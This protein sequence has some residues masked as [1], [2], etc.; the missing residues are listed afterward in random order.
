MLQRALRPHIRRDALRTRSQPSLTAPLAPPWLCPLHARWSTRIASVPSSV[1]QCPRQVAPSR[2]DT[3]SVATITQAE[4]ALHDSHAFEGLSRAFTSRTQS[5]HPELAQLPAWDS[6]RLLLID[7][8]PSLTTKPVTPTKVGVGGDPTELHQ[9]L[10]ACLR[11]GRM[12]R[13]SAILQRLS[14]TYDPSAPELADAH[15]LYL[16]T[17]FEV[18]E[19]NPSPNAMTEIEAWYETNMVAKGI[20]PTPQTLVTLLRASMNFPEP[21]NREGIMRR[22]LDM[23]REC[24][25]AF[26]EDVNASPDFTDE[27]WD[28]LIKLQSDQ[29]DVPPAPEAVQKMHISTPEGMALAIQHGFVPDP[30]LA[31]KPVD[32]KGL[33]L[34]SLKQALNLFEGKDTIPYPHEMEGSKE[35]K[36]RAY[37]YMRQIRLEQDALRAATERWQA[38]DEKLQEMG[39]HGVLQS[40]PL[41]A[42]LWR[43]YSALLPK[44]EE[45]L[46]R[47]REVLSNPNASNMRDERHIYGPHLEDM[48]LKDLAATTLVR[49]LS[50]VASG[51]S[52]ALKL[53]SITVTIGCDIA[54]LYHVNAKERYNSMV[55][56]LRT[57]TRRELLGNLSKEP[58]ATTVESPAPAAYISDDYQGKEIPDVVR[59]K[60]GA[61]LL[62]LAMQ[63]SFITLTRLDPKTGEEL[64]S[65]QP[66]FRQNSTYTLGKRITYIV[67]HDEIV[68]KLQTDRVDHIHTVRLPMLAEPKP[69]TA[70]HE[71]GYYTLREAAVRA[72]GLD[73]AQNAYITSA[74]ENG[75]ME[76]VLAGLDALGRVPWKINK[77]VFRVMVES[78]N[79]GLDIAGLVPDEP[80]LRKPEVP[81]EPS[82][83]RQR[84]EYMRQ[85]KDYENTKQG[86]HSEKCFQNFQLEVARSYLNE[87]K[88][89]Y[90][91]SVDFRGRA[92]PI[93]PLL[94]HIG[95][96]MSRGLLLFA[97]GKE[98]GES[99]LQWLKIHMANLYG[100]DKASLKDREIFTDNNLDNILDSANNPVD[101]KRWWSQA[102]DPWQCL[103][104]CVEIRNALQ[105]PDPTRYVSH[106]PVHQD[107]TC[108]G[109]QHYAALGGDRAGASQVNLE[110][111]DKPQ[112]IY[113]GV[114]EIVKE[115]VAKDAEKD[116]PF[117][118]FVEGKITRSVVK[119]TVMTNV[120]GVTF[121]GAQAQV[122][123]SLKDMF[124]NFTPQGGIGDLSGP[125]YYIAKKIFLALGRIFN[126][127]QEIQTWLGECGDRITSSLS[128][129]QVQKIK[130]RF[131]GRHEMSYDPK[132]SKTRKISNRTLK[133]MDQEMEAFKSTI[134]W[135]TPLKMPVVQPYRKSD[136]VRSIKTSVSAISIRAPGRVAVVSKRKQLQAFPPNFIHSLDATHMTLSAL[137]CAE[138]GIDFAAVHDSFWTHA[139]D[140]PNLNVILRNAFVRMHSE[141]IVGRL[142]AEFKAR[143]AGSMYLATVKPQS[144]VAM[145]IRTWR[146]EHR[147]RRGFQAHRE[148]PAEELALEAQRQ[149]L[150]RSEDPELRKKGEE[151]TTPTSI[152]LRYA[153]PTSLAS[154]RLA[155]LGQT[156]GKQAKKVQEKIHKS[157]TEVIKEV[158]QEKGVTDE[159]VVQEGVAQEVAEKEVAE[160]EDEL[161][162]EEGEAEAE[163]EAIEEEEGESPK[164]KA[165][166]YKANAYKVWLPLTFPPVPK[167]GDWDISRLHESKYFFS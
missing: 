32:Q 128:A 48:S 50:A 160:E 14:D 61:L 17:M 104:C 152:W 46:E 76:Q 150:L 65:T 59:V 141:D 63:T 9:N 72:K 147:N 34:A 140:I 19:Q 136:R 153:D 110:P 126:G 146:Q 80:D 97:N 107:G 90:P 89:F 49:L 148:A 132:Y 142:A 25:P 78:W 18:A 57:Q 163:A 41:Q 134:I 66:A 40:K 52:Q 138:E 77:D 109:L 130:E 115:M 116:M 83:N 7:D 157:E 119:R 165:K 51:S 88:I 6:S 35:E 67:P 55:R 155:L 37:A 102:E 137:K 70:L 100:Y 74:M 20:D 127:A 60:L 117:S 125:A 71:G 5:L 62:G 108:N 21:Q 113:T 81:A 36:D 73:V 154:E 29:Y 79:K 121:R 33:G 54:E 144:H 101:G 1:P 56:K 47:V 98:L 43:W 27:E 162:L 122:F 24:G 84:S 133:D 2:Q 166:V 96:D 131:E 112:D 93:P 75:D 135:T 92:Y 156:N 58:H 124:P 53:T 85:L 161:E 164:P 31:V 114:A 94:N 23:A 22:Y 28:S 129:E 82:T 4:P 120:Y 87:E 3:R 118:K 26:L 15:S 99:G 10:Y 38:E 68:K 8:L 45:E 69:W 95:A 123:D 44:L 167:K 13:A 39:I 103:A 16:Q 12:E 111:S 159:V 139:S 64:R 151:M 105:L 91:H 106:L 149:E 86:L 158:A 11:V 145:A 42:L 30:T 143:Y